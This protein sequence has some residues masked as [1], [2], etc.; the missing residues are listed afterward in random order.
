M[1][2]DH[3]QESDRLQESHW[4]DMWRPFLFQPPDII[5]YMENIEQTAESE[6]TASEYVL[7]S[8]VLMCR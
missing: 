8:I 4:K 7:Y 3:K 1:T 5:R 6:M 2:A